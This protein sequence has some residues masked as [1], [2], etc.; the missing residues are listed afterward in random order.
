MLICISTLH[1][2]VWLESSAFQITCIYFCT[3]SYILATRGSIW[4]K[5][6]SN[7]RWS[8][9]TTSKW[10]W[11]ESVADSSLFWRNP[12]LACARSA[13]WDGKRKA[14]T[15]PASK[16][17]LATPK[18]SKRSVRCCCRC[19]FGSSVSLAPKNVQL[20]FCQ[21]ANFFPE[22]KSKMAGAE[23]LMFC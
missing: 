18:H 8:T 13:D 11:K 1:T 22:E 14:S 3:F 7:Q 16:T 12:C 17:A 4:R 20:W 2:S 19:C 15:P 10:L 6:I 5:F 9:K 21:A 23:L